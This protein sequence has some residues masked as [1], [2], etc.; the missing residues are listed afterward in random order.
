MKVLITG[1]K[2]QL[3]IALNKL[4]SK[5]KDIEIVNT[6][7]DDMDITNIE[8]VRK[9]LNK[10][11]PN[12]V[13]NCAAYTKVDECETHQDLAFKVNADGVKN[14]A[15]ATKEIDATLIHVSTDYVFDGTKKEAYN[16]DD[17]TNP[18]SVYGKSKKAGEDNVISTLDKYFIV[19]TAWLYGIGR[20]FVNKMLELSEK[21]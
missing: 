4:L 17:K 3:G 10:Y 5:R 15:V 6:D 18:Q 7:I 20:N 11:N 2:G 8:D 9:V 1:S 12:Y 21:K 19:R 13:I 14:I 16:E